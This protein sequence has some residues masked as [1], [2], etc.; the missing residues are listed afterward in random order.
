MASAEKN[1]TEQRKQITA[2]LVLSAC[3]DVE[4]AQRIASCLVAERLAACVNLIPQMQSIYRWQDK[5]EQTNE[6][7]LLIKS[8]H[9]TLSDLEARLTALHPYDVPEFLV[10]TIED[11]SADYLAWL[12]QCL[13][14]DT[15]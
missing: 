11:G 6:V 3:P 14:R 9:G 4:H 12:G 5:I 7:Q 10:V 8:D 2:K 15:K 13:Q 1:V